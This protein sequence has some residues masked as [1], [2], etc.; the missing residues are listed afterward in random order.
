MSQSELIHS[1]DDEL[2]GSNGDELMFYVMK[3]VIES[4]RVDNPRFS[5][6]TRKEL[7]DNEI[8]RARCFKSVMTE[9]KQK[10]PNWGEE[11]N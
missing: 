8:T 7:L 5:T 11:W 3:I 2:Y 1:S 10:D 9:L 6:P 4:A